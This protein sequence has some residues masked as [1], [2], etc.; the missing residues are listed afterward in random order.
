MGW[1]GA[2]RRLVRPL[3]HALAGETLG[4]LKSGSVGNPTFDQFVGGIRYTSVAELAGANANTT[5]PLPP[6]GFP[7]FGAILGGKASPRSEV[8]LLLLLDLRKV[9]TSLN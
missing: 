1:D 2:R 7:I 3:R 4:V 5:G 8:L 6:D 9:L